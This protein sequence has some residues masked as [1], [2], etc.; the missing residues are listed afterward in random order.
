MASSQLLSAPRYVFPMR[1]AR[2][3]LPDCQTNYRE[4]DGVRYSRTEGVVSA[5]WCKNTPLHAISTRAP[6]DQRLVSW[7]QSAIMIE[8]DISLIQT[9]VLGGMGTVV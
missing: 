3:L 8:P 1:N 6:A 7:D 4:M 9:W 5:D 2:W